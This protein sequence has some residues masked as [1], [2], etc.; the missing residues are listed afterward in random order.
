MGLSLRIGVVIGLVLASLPLAP[1]S[2]QS[3]D[4]LSV[5]EDWSGARIR[6][7]RWR[8]GEVSNGQEVLREL[9]S[10]FFG[11]YLTMSLRREGETDSNA[12]SRTSS[13][14]LN[15]ANPASIVQIE[16]LMGVID[17]QVEQCQTN[18]TPSEA[19]LLIAMTPFNNGSSTG[20][21]DRTGDYNAL[22]QA[23]RRSNSADPGGILRVEGRV[24][25]CQNPACSNER[26]I[27]APKDL[28]V[29]LAVGEA[30]TMRL[31]WDAPNNQ[32][33]AGVNA[34]AVAL[35]YAPANDA[36][37]AAQRS[38]GIEIR[39]TTANCRA[40][41]TEADLVAG[42]G[43]VR[44]SAAGPPVVTPTP[45]PVTPPPVTP[46]PP[47]PPPVTPPPVTPPP[48][49]PPPVTPPPGDNTPF[50]FPD[51]PPYNP[52][53][54]SARYT[55]LGPDPATGGNFYAALQVYSNPLPGSHQ[56]AGLIPDGRRL[57]VP[58]DAQP[59][60]IRRV[61]QTGTCSATC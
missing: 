26:E 58:K 24:T 61:L 52:T 59:A 42:V 37:P 27:V 34:N 13:T 18:V 17:V 32:F 14:F 39:N 41:A 53:D 55:A 5:Y 25:R 51:Q 49:T 15:F 21:G 44:T 56:Y 38:A 35:P 57:W 2:G 16:A 22:V 20:P 19:R 4:A 23:V 9:R 1:G 7:D 8:G 3:Q 50:V 31:T 40:G 43:T 46:P 48:V 12:G 6:G 33:L 54:P 10:A 11:S 30:F 47:T 60:A 45:P 28:G 36:D 29:S